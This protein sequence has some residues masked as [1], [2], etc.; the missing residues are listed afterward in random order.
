MSLLLEQCN[1]CVTWENMYTILSTLHSFEM[2]VTMSLMA[3]TS[4]TWVYVYIL[5]VSFPYA[6]TESYKV[7]NWYIY[8][9]E[10]SVAKHSATFLK[11][12]AILQKMILHLRKKNLKKKC[13]QLI[14]C[15]ES[16]SVEDFSHA[17]VGLYFF[18]C[19]FDWGF[20]L[21]FFF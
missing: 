13:N 8:I 16:W 10:K 17:S 21:R 15:Q 20:C 7:G 3:L 2:K 18:C 9:K 4:H 12:P 1:P 19:L 5:A 14:L 6:S 11:L